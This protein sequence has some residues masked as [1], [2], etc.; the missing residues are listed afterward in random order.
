MKVFDFDPAEYTERYRR[1]G[2]VHIRAGMSSEFHASLVEYANSELSGHMLDGFAIKGKKQQALYEFPDDIDF[3]E[4]YDAVSTLCGLDRAKI[5]LSER[6]IQAYEETAAAEPAAHK[7]RFPSQ[8]SVGFSITIP[9]ESRLVLYPYD[10]RETNPFNTSAGL[11]RHLTP[12]EL[13]EV[14]LKGARELELD[15]RD[16]DIVMFPGSTTWHLRR[17]AAGALNLYLKFNDF[18]CD[19]LGEDPFTDSRRAATLAAVDANDER[20]LEA[21]VPVLSRRLDSVSRTYTRHRFTEAL[22][23]RL[24]GEEPLGVSE[25]Q[26]EALHVIDGTSPLTT[27]MNRLSGEP[28]SVRADLLH[29]A[30]VGLIDLVPATARQSVSAAGEAVQV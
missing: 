9:A 24:F 16:R 27:V 23:A 22:E 2:Y 28:S 3:G 15:D 20:A 14:A 4:I 18:D 30:R 12:N 26:F 1:D 25:Q 10:R 6:H 11:R 7:D 17:R 29:L 19:P 13:P 5:A 21:S 8:V